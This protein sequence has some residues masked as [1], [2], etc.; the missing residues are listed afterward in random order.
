MITLAWNVLINE[1][2]I[3]SCL[4]LVCL[5]QW[6]NNLS[7][8]ISRF[9]KINVHVIKDWIRKFGVMTIFKLEMYYNIYIWF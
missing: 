1:K 7:V 2:K 5:L 8:I 3:C 4:H 6:E 9:L